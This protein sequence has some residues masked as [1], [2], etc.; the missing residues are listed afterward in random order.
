MKH[1]REGNIVYSYPKVS[2]PLDYMTLSV[3][4]GHISLEAFPVKYEETRSSH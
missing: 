2:L 1:Q 4:I 3:E